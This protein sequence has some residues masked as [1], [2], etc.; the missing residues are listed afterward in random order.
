MHEKRQR[1]IG[2]RTTMVVTLQNHSGILKSTT[3]I[4]AAEPWHN[5]SHVSSKADRGALEK[6][7]GSQSGREYSNFGQLMSTLLFGTASL[8]L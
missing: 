4:N 1:G 3:C 7:G 6:G 2:H 8:S 5:A